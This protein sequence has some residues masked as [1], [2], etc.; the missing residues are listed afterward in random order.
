MTKKGDLSMMRRIWMLYADGF[1]N[2][3]PWARSIWMIILIKVFIMFAI[4]K[5]FFFRDTLNTRFATD[6]ERSSFVIEQITK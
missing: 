5:L 2:L 3:P 6:E 1:R 4:F